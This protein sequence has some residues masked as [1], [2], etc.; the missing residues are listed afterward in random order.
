MNPATSSFVR[1]ESAVTSIE[2]ALLSSLIALVIVVS[3]TNLGI[4]VL[5]LY[6]VVSLAVAAAA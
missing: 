6:Q 2:Y 5:A 4:N 1:D 3:V